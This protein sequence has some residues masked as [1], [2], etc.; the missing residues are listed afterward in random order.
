MKT[1]MQSTISLLPAYQSD[2]H[3]SKEVHDLATD[4]ALCS[5]FSDQKGKALNEIKKTFEKEIS[6][7][8]QYLQQLQAEQMTHQRERSRGLDL[9]M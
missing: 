8:S 5:I 4:K 1:I 7:T 3:S 6:K 2:K 9:F